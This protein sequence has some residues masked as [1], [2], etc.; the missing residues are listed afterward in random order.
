MIVHVFNKWFQ[1]VDFN[2]SL[3]RGVLQE[4]LKIFEE[5]PKI[6]NNSLNI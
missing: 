6:S 3:A 2:S 5:L 4:G 1:V